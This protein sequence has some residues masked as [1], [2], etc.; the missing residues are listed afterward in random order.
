MFGEEQLY[1]ILPASDP[2]PHNEKPEKPEALS[3]LA[4]MKEYEGWSFRAS[5]IE[6]ED[7]DD[8]PT[9]NL[10]FVSS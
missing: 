5:I 9:P 1:C 4:V 3:F 7:N 10:L 8:V 2:L 6:F